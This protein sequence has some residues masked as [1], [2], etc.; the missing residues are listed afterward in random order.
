MKTLWSILLLVTSPCLATM[1]Q[2]DFNLGRGTPSSSIQAQ[3]SS[4]NIGS[5]GTDWSAD[6]FHQVGPRVYWGLGGGIFRSNDRASATFIPSATTTLTSK[7]TSILVLSRTDLGNQAKFVPYLIAGIGWVRNSLS[8]V[9]GS[10]KLLDDSK[11]TLAYATGLGLDYALNDRLVIGME[12]R[13]QGSL[14]ENFAYT[15]DGNAATGQNS[16]HTPLTVLSVGVK[17]GIKY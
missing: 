8:V 4:E 5:R 6:I 12:A 2:I 17:A 13:Y 3:G 11:D 15:P 7:A 1:N 10:T 16:V 14:N 9:T